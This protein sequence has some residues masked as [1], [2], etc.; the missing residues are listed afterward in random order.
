MINVNSIPIF[1]MPL[2][3]IP[4]LWLVARVRLDKQTAEAY[5]L[6]FRKIFNHCFQSSKTFEVGKT[7][8]GVVIDWSDAEAAGL[9]LAVGE[10]K[11]GELLKGC[12]VHWQRSCQ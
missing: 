10:H 3:L 2:H 1:L 6:A 5:A 11:A 12:K 7:L 9:N 8:F 4:Q